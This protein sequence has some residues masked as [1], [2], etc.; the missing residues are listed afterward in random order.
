MPID[1]LDLEDFNKVLDITA[2]PGGKTSQACAL[3][4]N[5]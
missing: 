5:T 2:A 1:F 4:K 3:L